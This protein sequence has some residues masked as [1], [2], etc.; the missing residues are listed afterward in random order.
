MSTYYAN[1]ALDAYAAQLAND[2]QLH[3]AWEDTCAAAEQGY[4]DA[5]DTWE[6]HPTDDAGNPLPEPQPPTLP[7]EPQP[8]ATVPPVYTE[9]AID[10]ATE[11]DTA[12]GPALVLPPSVILTGPDGA[13]FAILPDD[14]TR[15]FTATSKPLPSAKKR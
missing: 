13:Q 14:L 5:H 8:T 10:G 6:Q 7:D 3:K 11:L 4:Q 12:A 1:T 15:T 2:A 9:S